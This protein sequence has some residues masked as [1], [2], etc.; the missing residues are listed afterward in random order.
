MNVKR[1]LE[2]GLCT[3]VAGCA[4]IGHH[5]KQQY[6]CSHESYN[7][8]DFSSHRQAVAVYQSCGGIYNDIHHLD[9][10]KDGNP[11]ETLK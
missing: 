8:S 6:T 1:T 2:I 5:T 3:L 10:D 9:K 4:T 11:C 7:C